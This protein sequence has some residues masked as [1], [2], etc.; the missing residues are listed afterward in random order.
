MICPKC[1]GRRRYRI[2]PTDADMRDCSEC[3]GTGNVKPVPFTTSPT[4]APL[5]NR[6]CL[7]DP[8]HFAFSESDIARLPPNVSVAEAVERGMLTTTISGV[9]RPIKEVRD[10]DVVNRNMQDKTL[11]IVR[12]AMRRGVRVVADH[13]I[14]SGEIALLVSP[15]TLARI[16]EKQ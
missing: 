8:E 5:Y 14:H 13:N 15:A 1:Q 12:E 2:G 6:N 4:M 9:S 10:F 3:E 7:F 11:E 16:K